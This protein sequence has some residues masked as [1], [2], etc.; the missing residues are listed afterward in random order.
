MAKK[1]LTKKMVKK[2][3]QE[4]GFSEAMIFTAL[5]FGVIG[6]YEFFANYKKATKRK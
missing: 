1:K 3:S 4:S 5:S 2:L 6:A